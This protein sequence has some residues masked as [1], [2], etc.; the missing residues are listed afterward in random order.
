M[1]GSRSA[2]QCLHRWQQILRPG[3]KKGTWT[4]E[5]DSIIVG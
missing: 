1:R 5:E 3:L 2:T 4:E